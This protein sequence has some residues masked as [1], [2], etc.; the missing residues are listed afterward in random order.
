[1]ITLASSPSFY[2]S[3][4]IAEAKEKFPGLKYLV[5][6]GINEYGASIQALESEVNESNIIQGVI[7]TS[8]VVPEYLNIDQIIKDG[9]RTPQI[10]IN[11]IK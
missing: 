8:K 5:F 11:V 4:L 9:S 1:L 2:I 6:K 3:T 10:F 7:E